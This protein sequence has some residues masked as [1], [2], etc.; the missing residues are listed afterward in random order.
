MGTLVASLRE[1]SRRAGSALLGVHARLATPGAAA[2][3]ALIEGGAPGH[4]AVV[5][6]S[7][8]AAS[9][10]GGVGGGAR[11]LGPCVGLVSAASGST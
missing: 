11:G 4:L 9:G 7:S 5:R 3:R 2:Y 10:V 6:A 8:G 1:G